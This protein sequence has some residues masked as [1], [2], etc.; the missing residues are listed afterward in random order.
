MT[1]HGWWIALVAFALAG[2][3]ATAQTA[4]RAA[5]R[6][7]LRRFA[8]AAGDE[9]RAS[10][11]L[12]KRNEHALAAAIARI[13]CAIFGVAALLAWAVGNQ[14]AID[15]RLL[16]AALAVAA[17]AAILYI[18]T[19]AIPMSIADH[20]GE[21]VV[22]TLAPL[23]R[24]LRFVLR[25]AI[26]AAAV[27]DEIIRRLAGVP[28]LSEEEELEEEI[29]SVVS[30]RSEEGALDETGRDMIEAVVD[31]RTATVEEIMT[32]RTEVEGIEISSDLAAVRDFIAEAGHSR[33]PVYEDNLDNI[34]GLLYAKD[35]LRYL[36][37]HTES[38]ALR[39]VLR[40]ARFV[41]ETKRLDELLTE[42]QRDK[43]H[44]AIVLDEYGG[45]AGLVTIEDV[46]EEI[47]GEIHDEHEPETDAPPEIKLLA[48]ERA[49]VVDARAYIDDV[50][51]QLES[52]SPHQL[53]EAEDYDTVGG[54]VTTALGHIPVAGESFRHNGFLVTVLEAEPTRVAQVRI[55]P[56]GEPA[57]EH[58][59]P[60]PV[61]PSADAAAGAPPEEHAADTP[62]DQPT[63]APHSA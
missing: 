54:Y 40:E 26:A 63:D 10:D 42:F 32:P 35:L 27:A 31:F 53:P 17:A 46:I 2:L 55:E 29:R 38:F 41:P 3:F 34:A 11:I 59:K 5:S 57:E 28:K 12:D 58:D 1:A 19:A 22:L 13:T 36:G 43:V 33:I 30:E 21:H 49:A 25:P 39:D 14:A 45:T 24:F 48:E 62:A 8:A 20:A 15:Q 47:V 51:D 4:L 18:L 7:R 50:N 56:T 44:L 60:T 16:P 23:L 9:L 37:E 6:A 61:E 52:L